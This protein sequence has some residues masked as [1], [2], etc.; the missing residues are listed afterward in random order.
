MKLLLFACLALAVAAASSPN[1]QNL[2]ASPEERSRSNNGQ[3]STSQEE[4]RNDEEDFTTPEGEEELDEIDDRPTPIRKLSESKSDEESRVPVTPPT[5]TEQCALC[6]ATWRHAIGVYNSVEDVEDKHGRYRDRRRTIQQRHMITADRAQ[7]DGVRIGDGIITEEKVCRAVCPAEIREELSLKNKEDLDVYTCDACKST[8][9]YLRSQSQS[10]NSIR[11]SARNIMCR[12]FHTQ[13]VR[14]D[15]MHTV[16]LYGN[17]IR[18][19]IEIGLS[20]SGVCR[21][22]DMCDAELQTGE[23]EQESLLRLFEEDNEPLRQED[24]EDL[25]QWGFTIDE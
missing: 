4:L 1:E 14:D 7:R 23:D 16:H 25:K 5:Q 9:K 18:E 20:P 2:S 8:V 13:M 15:C 6:L 22:Y 17:S 11:E 24:L 12:R 10:I 21:N 3:F 19:D